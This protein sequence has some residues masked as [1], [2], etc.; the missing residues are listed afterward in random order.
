VDYFLDRYF[1]WHAVHARVVAVAAAATAAGGSGERAARGFKRRRFALEVRPVFPDRRPRPGRMLGTAGRKQAW[2]ILCKPGDG[3][4]IRF[5]P[6][7]IAFGFDALGDRLVALGHAFHGVHAFL[8]DPGGVIVSRRRHD[9]RCGG[10]RAKRD[11]CSFHQITFR[12]ANT[13][14]LV[15]SLP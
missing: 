8:D 7:E 15:G 9:G 2:D 1:S 5:D 3:L 11:G 14:A 13:I 12:R 4:G 6:G 10:K